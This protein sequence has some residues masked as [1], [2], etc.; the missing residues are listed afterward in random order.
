M[1]DKQKTLVNYIV[2]FFIGVLITLS[3][4]IPIHISSVRRANQKSGELSVRLSEAD[5]RLTE[6][7]ATITDLRESSERISKAAERGNVNLS[8]IIDC[9]REIRK[10]VQIM[11][12][13]L[14]Y[15]DN[16]I[17]NNN[18]N[19]RGPVIPSE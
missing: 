18:G 5:K 14:Y 19:N 11:E 3:I 15:Y 7:T 6:A 2:C 8:G 17:S 10:E 9:L 1:N 12:E 16:N 13:R 4:S